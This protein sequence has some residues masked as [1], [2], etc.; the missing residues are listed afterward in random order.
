MYPVLAGLPRLWK[1]DHQN[2]GL[3]LNIQEQIKNYK[4]CSEECPHTDLLFRQK[5]CVIWFNNFLKVYLRY[6][7]Q[8]KIH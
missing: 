7:S 8:R 4:T 6:S 2:F 5:I 1:L 3:V